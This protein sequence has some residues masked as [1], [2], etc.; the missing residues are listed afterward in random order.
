MD[1]IKYTAADYKSD[2]SVRWCPGCGDH[3]ILNVLH[4]AMA[5][6]G[7]APHNTAVISGIGCSSRLPYYMNTYGFHTIHGRAAAVAT[8]FKVAN[9][10]MTVWQISGDGDGL[11]IGGNHFIHA[12]RR[13]VDINLLL[14]NNKIYGLTKGQ[15]SPTSARGFV[16]KSSPYGTTEDPFIPAELVFGARGNFFG[17]SIDVDLPIA[18]EV[19]V[20]AARHRGTSVV[21]MLQNCVIFNNGIHNYISDR[22]FRAERTIHLRHGEKMLFG[23]NMEK[24]LVRDGFLLKAVELGK[25]GYTI[26]DVLVHDAHTPSNFLH[27]QLAMMDGYDLPLAVGVIR[28]VESPVYNEEIDMQIEQVRAKKGFDRLR[29]MIL[30]GE[31]W[32]VK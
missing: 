10:A 22:E 6:I 13:N 11:A 1:C 14:F 18:Q 8:G 29:D 15:Y 27:Q 5:E 12:V 25:D 31:T 17:R 2:Q 19:M 28:D 21:E 3:A 9:P 16:S 26:D 32:E 23:K 4:K 20:A 30:A 7:V 24:G